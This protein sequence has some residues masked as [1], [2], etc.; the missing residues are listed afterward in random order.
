MLFRSLVDIH[1]SKAPEHAEAPLRFDHE[2]PEY[3]ADARASPFHSGLT[4]ARS[5]GCPPVRCCWFEIRALGRRVSRIRR[6][7]RRLEPEAG[8]TGGRPRPVPRDPSGNRAEPGWHIAAA[9]YTAEGGTAR[10]A[11]TRP[12]EHT[13]N[14]QRLEEAPRPARRNTVPVGKRP[15]AAPERAPPHRAIRRQHPDQGH[16]RP[17]PRSQFPRPSRR[18]WPTQWRR[19][20]N[21]SPA[22]NT[23]LTPAGLR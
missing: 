3:V 14:R 21:L 4:G 9:A 7:N 6:S 1:N 17:L 10:A 18:A 22:S 8:T 16:P 2:F 23:V 5:T 15:K 20:S 13:P 19:S 12:E 11:H